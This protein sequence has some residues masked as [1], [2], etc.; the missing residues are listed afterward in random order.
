M[1]SESG[2]AHGT[3]ST[4]CERATASKEVADI[5]L[6][7][8]EAHITAGLAL[9]MTEQRSKRDELFGAGT[10]RAVVQLGR[11]TRGIEVLREALQLGESV[12]A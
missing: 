11:V 10:M 12:V 2:R 7:L 3:K 5:A 4:K 8:I 6:H 1:P 9:E